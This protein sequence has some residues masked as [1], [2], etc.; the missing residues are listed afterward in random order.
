MNYL[1]EAQGNQEEV[2]LEE[3]SADSQRAWLWCDETFTLSALR[4]GPRLVGFV[5]HDTVREYLV[6]AA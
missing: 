4:S 3:G 6:Y 2:A 5:W 1:V